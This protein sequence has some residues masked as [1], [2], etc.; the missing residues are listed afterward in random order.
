[1]HQFVVSSLF[2]TKMGQLAQV[3][4]PPPAIESPAC[5]IAGG[6]FSA[7]IRDFDYAALKGRIPGTRN[8][9]ISVNARFVGC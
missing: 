2:R 6:A 1:M 9:S 4:P 5:R 8:G 7:V 3:L